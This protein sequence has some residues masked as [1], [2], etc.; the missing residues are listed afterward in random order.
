MTGVN[1]RSETAPAAGRAQP[2]ATNAAHGKTA[3]G[4]PSRWLRRSLAAG[5]VL[6]VALG[7][8]GGARVLTRPPQLSVIAVR[9]GPVTRML[10]VTGSIEAARRVIVSPRSTARITA[11][12]RAEG[13][14]VRAGE[15]LARLADV[16]ATS[17]VLQQRASL[18][19]KR[20]ERA[21]AD[22]DL[23]RAELLGR[24]GATSA[25]ALE[26]ARL[27]AVRGGEEVRRLDA[28]LA[29]G[30]AQLQLVAPFDG[31]ITRRMAELGQVVSPEAAVFEI[32][33]L[34]DARATAEVDERYLRALQLGMRAEVLT[35]GAAAERMPAAISYVARAVD[36]QTGAATVR[37]AFDHPPRFVLVGASVDIN[38]RVD[39]LPAALTV[40]RD[41]IGGTGAS[42]F[43]TVV[44][45]GTTQ[46]RNVT[47]DDWPAAAVVV[48]SGLHAGDQVARD[49]A[50]FPSGVRVRAELGA[51]AL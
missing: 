46:R 1:L 43:V 26:A 9:E 22:H 10:A 27:T 44:A 2:A 48:R 11:I 50:A 17:N 49:P 34:D 20:A 16:S 40:P 21:Q 13:E 47:F 7:A 12:L 31:T 25:A 41:V 51:D 42:A 8:A 4:P 35:L 5:I 36:G 23:V 3:T 33:S 30:R 38:V 18:A 15:P 29:E 14:Y 39:T 24:A 6:L 45:D 19:S 37:F 32:A 28:L